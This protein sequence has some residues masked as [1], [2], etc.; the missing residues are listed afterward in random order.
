VIFSDYDIALGIVSYLA[1]NSEEAAIT[2]IL[3]CLKIRLEIDSA[4]SE[5]NLAEECNIL[6]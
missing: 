1:L 3:K 2:Y 4:L 5:R 6:N